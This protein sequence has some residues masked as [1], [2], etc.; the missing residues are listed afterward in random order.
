M[1][2]F[3]LIGDLDHEV[4]MGFSFVLVSLLQPETLRYL[5]TKC[6]QVPWVLHPKRENRRP[7]TTAVDAAGAVRDTEYIF[8]DGGKAKASQS[9]ASWK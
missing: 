6:L 9:R 1:I 2:E 8:I 3:A 4:V 5:Y 7:S